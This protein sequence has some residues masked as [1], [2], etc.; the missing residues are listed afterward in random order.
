MIDFGKQLKNWAGSYS[1]V[2]G[3]FASDSELT[4]LNTGL[5]TH[6]IS[7]NGTFSH[8]DLLSFMILYR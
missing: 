6:Y 3:P 8:I 7:N 4:M 1:K 2:P 5:P